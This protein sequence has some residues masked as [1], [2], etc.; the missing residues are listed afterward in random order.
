MP[1][2][3]EKIFERE[4]GKEKGDLIFYKWMNKNKKK[5]KWKK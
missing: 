3:I 5:K 1:L 2:K 4:Y